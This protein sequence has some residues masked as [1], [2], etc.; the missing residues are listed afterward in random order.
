MAKKR[1]FKGEYKRRLKSAEAKGKTRQQAR[2]HQEAEHIVRAE[3]E[4]ENEGWTKAQEKVVRAW[5]DRFYNEHDYPEDA[6]VPYEDVET[7]VK[8]NGYQAY[9]VWRATWDAVRRNYLRELADGSYTSRGMGFLT[10][11]DENAG[12]PGAGDLTW[13]YYH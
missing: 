7:F 6:R 4:I 9:K 1:D 3:K 13:L 8:E 11:L 2:G 10:E 5:Y 12:S